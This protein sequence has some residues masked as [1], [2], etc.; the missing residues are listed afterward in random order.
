MKLICKILNIEIQYMN[1]INQELVPVK[2]GVG[3]GGSYK[4]SRNFV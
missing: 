2:T 4:P 3:V 1:E